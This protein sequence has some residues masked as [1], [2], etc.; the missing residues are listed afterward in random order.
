MNMQP[1]L[2]LGSARLR[3]TFVG[4]SRELVLKPE[5]RRI[6]LAVTI[7]FVWVF[8]LSALSKY[9]HPALE[10]FESGKQVTVQHVQCFFCI[11]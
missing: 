6:A 3:H 4:V 8:F 10:K 7:M 2:P 1:L 9:F 11:I 5:L